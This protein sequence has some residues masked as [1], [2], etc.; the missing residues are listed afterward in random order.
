M[1][2]PNDLALKVVKTMKSHNFPLFIGDN[3]TNIIYVEGM[4]TDG[5]KNSF[6][7]NAFDCVRSVVR[8]FLTVTLLYLEF[9]MR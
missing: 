2:N 6:R 5:T 1:I 8:V 3:V 7:P 4:D 9:G